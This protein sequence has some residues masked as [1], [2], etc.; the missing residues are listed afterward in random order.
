MEAEM[1]LYIGL[2]MKNK[3][4]DNIK[5]SNDW[6]L[7]QLKNG[8]SINRVTAETSWFPP[9]TLLKKDY[10]LVSRL[11]KVTEDNI[12]KIEEKLNKKDP[13]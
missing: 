8:G 11:Y 3:N 4:K 5:E 2:K 7:E 6:I 13:K 12:K 10:K 1:Y 9:K